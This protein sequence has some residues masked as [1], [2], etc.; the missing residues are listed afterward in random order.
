MKFRKLL[1]AAAMLCTAQLAMS[2]A[3]PTRPIKIIVAYPAGQGTDIATRY[4]ADQL[5]KELGQAVVIDNKPGAG[6][7]LGTEL[8]AQAPADGYTLTM[9]TN[10]THVLNQYLY[11]SLK[12]DGE[13]DFEPVA[14][15]GTF[16][17]MIAVNSKS[18]LQSVGDL[19]A[20]VKAGTRADIAMPSTTARLV[21][22]L[23]K[24]RSAT[25]LFSVPYKGSASAMT[26]VLGGQLPVIVDTPTALRSHVTSGTVRAIAVT[27]A[28]PSGLAPGVK[29]V[30]EQGFSGFEV[31]AWNGLYAPKGTPPAVINTLSAAIMKVIARPDAR[32]KLLDIGFDPAGGTPAQ[33]AE[34]GRAERRKW[35][36]I[37]KGAGLKAD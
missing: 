17:M 1:L 13:K 15:I 28:R 19:V 8:A 12:F 10:A 11:S 26:D 34:F 23:L 37:I 21:V 25:A 30:S 27:S 2:Q 16:P 4:I 29:T 24:E 32:Q 9:G 18:N 6:G 7:N 36:P 31:V 20:A 33:L 35:E 22:E 14:L 5:S 3:Y